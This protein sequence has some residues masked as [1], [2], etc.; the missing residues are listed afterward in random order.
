M[1]N[2]YIMQAA[3]LFAGDEDPNNAHYLDLTSVKLPMLQENSTDHKPGGGAMGIKIGMGQTE[4][5]SLSFKIKGMT[6]DLLVQYGIGLPRR[7]K[8]T[9]RGSVLD[10]AA[11]IEIPALAIAEGRIL[12]ADMSEFSQDNGVDTDYEV[13]E[14]AHYELWIGGKE[15]YYLNYRAGPAGV[16]INGI[17]TLSDRAR[18]LGLI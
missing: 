7:R 16:R 12:K 13:H 18:N 9:I 2:H 6:P 5:L 15:I 3:A 1:S 4:A 10:F 8:Y 17:P 11:N 14:L